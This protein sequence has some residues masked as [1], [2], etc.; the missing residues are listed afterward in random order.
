MNP[1]IINCTGMVAPADVEPLL[2]TSTNASDEP[3]DRCYIL[4]TNPLFLHAMGNEENA[5]IREKLVARLNIDYIGIIYYCKQAKQYQLYTITSEAVALVEE[6]FDVKRTAHI[7][8]ERL[9]NKHSNESFIRGSTQYH[10]ATPSHNHTNAFFR[11]G[12]SIKNRDDLDRVTFWLLKCVDESDYIFIDSW[13]IAA[14]PLRALQILSKDTVFDAL[15][16][17]PAKKI[18][19]CRSVVCAATPELKVSVSPLLLVSV[20]SSGSLVEKFK[21]IFQGAYASKKLS[22]VS[23]YSFVE[24]EYSYCCVDRNVVNYHFDNCE[25]C[26]KGSK[27]IEIHPS[28]YYIKDA[29]DSGV[30]LT[31]G[32]AETGY[33]FFHKYHHHLNDIVSFHKGDISKGNKHYAYYIDYN[34]ISSLAVFAK[35][36]AEQLASKLTNNSVVLSLVNDPVVEAEVRSQDA[37]F[38]YLNGPESTLE[39]EV[40]EC[41]KKSDKV[42]IYDSVTINGKSFEKLNNFIREN[43]EL[44]AAITNIIF[45]AGVYRPTS[46]LAE[47]ALQ[48][49][50]AYKDARVLREYSYIE[51]LVLPDFGPLDCPWCLELGAIKGSIKPALKGSGRFYERVS[52]LSNLHDGV[53]GT[54]AIFHIDESTEAL[55]LGADSYL[56][57]E[58]TAI[59]GVV[60]AVAS[61]LQQMRTAEDESKRLAP[62]FPYTQALG[63]IN[64][65][66]YSEGI[67]RAALIRNASAI[68]FGVIEKEKTLEILLPALEEINQ[69]SLLSEYI[70]AVICGKLPPS[71]ALS[72]A[73][74]VRLQ[75]L[76]AENPEIMKLAIGNDG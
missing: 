7:D 4:A 75:T 9:L 39:K 15:P 54:D 49:S 1:V 21:E 24:Q 57:P 32:I 14:I 30:K 56:A 36:L 42:I 58:K 65:S 11:L 31:R 23:V 16:A 68:E 61:A 62:G 34:Q 69:T 20:V 72:D 52:R 26:Q 22:I 3:Y 2:L 66:N 13:S 73:V 48:S 76:T 44:S 28:A 8:L 67:I 27:A 70:V 63:A 19:D 50:L 25:L 12:D 37:A 33:D 74:T 71:S 46:A 17:H 38:Y 51:K 53:R 60:L 41:V 45:L 6:G 5:P 43:A 59:C 29:T 64:F 40:L 35:A 18:I 10:F 55:T 47:K